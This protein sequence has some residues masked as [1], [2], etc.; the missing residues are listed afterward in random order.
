[1]LADS[2]T[3]ET[4]SCKSPSRPSNCV[5]ENPF[6]FYATMDDFRRWLVVEVM[7]KST[8][9]ELDMDEVGLFV[10]GSRPGRAS[11]GLR[12][13]TSFVQTGI[14]CCIIDC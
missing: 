12:P 4:G 3:W 11:C 1:M 7:M 8:L 14:Q 5:N 13:A 2:V 6:D 9:K 10:P